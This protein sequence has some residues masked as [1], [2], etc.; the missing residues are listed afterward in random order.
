MGL[1]DNFSAKDIAVFSRDF[2]TIIDIAVAMERNF[3]ESNPDFDLFFP[4]YKSLIKLFDKKYPGLFLK[5]KKTTNQL[6]LSI[7]FKGEKD[8]K[9]VFLSVASK[10]AGL[11]SIGA[12]YLGAAEVGTPRFNKELEKVK[13]KMQISYYDPDLGST[14]IFLEIDKKSKNVEIRYDPS[15]ITDTKD[16]EFKLC[17]YYALKD[18]YKKKIDVAKKEEEF[19]FNDWSEDAKQRFL[20]KYD[21]RLDE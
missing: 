1:L 12:T 7:S 6:R 11:K 2:T 10:I 14:S 16:P 19:A 18:G 5:L 20:D 21:P 8:I 4:R 15:M 17:C 9:D 13:N 3:F